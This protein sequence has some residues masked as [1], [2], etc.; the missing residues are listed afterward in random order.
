MRT[1]FTFLFSAILTLGFVV[2][3]P[4]N[5]CAELF[6]KI[7]VLERMK[8][9]YAMTE[10]LPPDPATLSAAQPAPP[11]PP[12][13]VKRTVKPAVK[14]PPPPPQL[15]QQA[16]QLIARIDN[17]EKDVELLSVKMKE[18]KAKQKG[19]SFGSG[20]VKKLQ[21]ESEKLTDRIKEMKIQLSRE[22]AKY[23]PSRGI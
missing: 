2:I 5:K 20:D 9:N 14:A 4:G 1:I 7:G 21:R 3:N 13:P 17:Y 15:S 10:T 22:K 19:S 8:D 12:A 16:R 11:P 23:S 18:A 6:E